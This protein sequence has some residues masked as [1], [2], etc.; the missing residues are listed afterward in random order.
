MGSAS[1]TRPRGLVRTRWTAVPTRNA[2]HP[3]D[4]SIAIVSRMAATAGRRGATTTAAMPAATAPI[5]P[6]WN[7][8]R[9]SSPPDPS[10]R[11]T[12]IAPSAQ[13]GDASRRTT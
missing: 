10:I 9:M 12:A 5:V 6:D 13:A 4:V 3:P 11:T 8:H 2:S 1:Q 7:A